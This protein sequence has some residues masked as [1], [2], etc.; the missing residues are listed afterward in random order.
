MRRVGV[1]VDLRVYRPKEFSR[2]Y[3]STLVRVDWSSGV[4]TGSP[5]RSGK[6]MRM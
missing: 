1:K 3:A 5:E 4:E 6:S 2:K